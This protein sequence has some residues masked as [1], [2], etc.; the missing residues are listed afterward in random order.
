MWDR[1]ATINSLD[2]LPD[3]DAY[4][5]S[6]YN[7]EIGSDIRRYQRDEAQGLATLE[8]QHG[9]DP[10]L[11]VNAMGSITPT[12]QGIQATRSTGGLIAF[13]DENQELTLTM[14]SPLW[15]GAWVHHLACLAL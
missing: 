13:F 3:E 14:K 15:S 4:L 7:Q 9:Q 5:T 12:A 8:W 6:I 11:Y 1:S 10:S 2:Y